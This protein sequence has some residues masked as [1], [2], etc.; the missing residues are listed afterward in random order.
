MEKEALK[1]IA[2]SG[3]FEQLPLARTA[4]PASLVGQ[5]RVYSDHKNFKRVEAES[6]VGALEMSG[7]ESAV[8]IEREATY[9]HALIAPNFTQAAP[10][11]EGAA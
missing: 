2:Q 4:A 9:K 10:P 11:V 8:K 7:L 6:A 5:Y 3:N 1:D